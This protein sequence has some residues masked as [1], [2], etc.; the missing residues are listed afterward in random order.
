[1][2]EVLAQ[3][4]VDL[5]VLETGSTWEDDRAARPGTLLQVS[6]FWGGEHVRA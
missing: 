4:R 1:M 6:L 3:K 2:R 5:V